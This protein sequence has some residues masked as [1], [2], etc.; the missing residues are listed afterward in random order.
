MLERLKKIFDPQS[1]LD[2]RSAESLVRAINQKKLKTFD[3]LRF[4][5]SIENMK[6]L[7]MEE[8]V[9]YKSAFA[10]AATMGLTKTELS[11][12]A[13]Y[14]KK[15]LKEEK[16]KFDLALRNKIDSKLKGRLEKTEKLKQTLIQKEKQIA[17][18][19]QDI[20][21]GRTQIESA[22]KVIAEDREKIKTLSDSFATTISEFGNVIDS[23]LEKINTYL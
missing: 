3:Y 12:T 8:D 19:Q 9:A 5:L 21:K 2:V 11:K 20:E 13:S 4:R 23:D 10:T 16:G 7:E 22:E 18:L 6:K 15:V 14:Y 1:K 17:Q